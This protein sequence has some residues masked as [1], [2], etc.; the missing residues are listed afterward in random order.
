MKSLK[1]LATTVLLSGTITAALVC[2][3]NAQ[4][5]AFKEGTHAVSLGYGAVTFMGTLNRAFEPYA[6]LTYSTLGPA[7]F[8]YEYGISNNIGLGLSFA[9]EENDWTY[10]YDSID[11][12]GNPAQYSESTSRSTYSILARFNFHMGD[13][14]KFDPYIGFGVGY[15]DANWDIRSDSP[16]GDSG[17]SLKSL[18]PFGFE[19]TVGARYFFLDNLGI[20]AEMGGAKSVFQG[21]LTARF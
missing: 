14:E 2:P 17:V 16:Y 13:S 18:I 1:T 15:R 6:D 8:K 12:D 4:A 20:Y 9:Y 19:L 21:G 3:S 5:Q 7:Y 11:L 10:R